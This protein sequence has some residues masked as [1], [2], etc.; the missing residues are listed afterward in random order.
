M[1][2]I[3]PLTALAACLAA[4]LGVASPA[5]RAV[6]RTVTQCGDS[7]AGSLRAA[8]ASAS[9]LGDTIVFDIAQMACSKI[10]LTSGQ[11]VVNAQTLT[12]QGP[13]SAL[14]T[15]SGNSGD[16]AHASRVFFDRANDATGYTRQLTINDLTISEGLAHANAAAIIRGGCVD[17]SGDVTLIRA[18]VTGCIVENFDQAGQ[19]NGGGINARSLHMSYSTI[20]NSSAGG[21]SATVGG[22]AS[23]DGAIDIRFSR[24]IGNGTA[25]GNPQLAPGSGGGIASFGQAGGDIRI[26]ASTL[27]GN[28]ADRGGALY[29]SVPVGAG[30]MALTIDHSTISGNHAEVASGAVQLYDSNAHMTA[31]I[32]D[33]TISGNNSSQFTGGVFS[34]ASQL[35]VSNSTIAFNTAAASSGPTIASGLYSSGVT[36][37]QSVI[38]AKNL[39]N[40]P[41]DLGGSSTFSGSGNLIMAT[42]GGAVSPVGSL[43]ADPQLGGLADN[44]G[45]TLTHALPN[46]SPAIG[47]GNNLGH[48]ASDQRGA[49]FARMTGNKTDIGAFQH[50]DGIFAAGFE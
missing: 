5:A 14:L 34:T 23:I 40:G 25:T 49:G 9:N 4:A 35:T 50:G 47:S 36:I 2:A 22:A 28:Q 38:L 7:G 41:S 31:I 46:G 27:A 33:S 44:G 42:V 13:G 18:V 16:Y 43:T 39:N 24:I 21:S 45:M 3:P 29:V 19:A 8:V 30:P 12:V 10:T 15:V 48:L 20:S 6:N 17:A 1:R 37:L 11:I 26:I 32:L